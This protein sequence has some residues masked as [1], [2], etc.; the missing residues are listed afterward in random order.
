MIWKRTFEMR[1][2]GFLILWAFL[3]F[4]SGFAQD[5][6]ACL[7][8]HNDPELTME[9]KGREISLFIDP[10][11]FGKSAHAKASCIDC[12]SG[13]DPDE[14]PHKEDIQ[15][16][17]CA[18]CHRGEARAFH[19]GGH[20]QKLNCASCHQ[21]AHAPENK[22][23]L[24]L[25]CE[26]C[27]KEAK[28]SLAGS[29]HAGA[30][31]SPTCGNCHSP[32]QTGAVDSQKC[33]N[34]HGEKEFVH[35]HAPDKAEDYVLKYQDSI[36]GENIECSDCHGGHEIAPASSPESPV[37][38]SNI[39]NT[40]SQC[41]DEVAEKFLAS[42]HGKALQ[43]G[44][45]SAPTCTDCHG[46]HD[47]HQITDSRSKVSRQHEVEVC[48]KC[49]LDSPEVQA[50]MTHSAG[51]V[52]GY[53][54]S[55]HGRALKEGNLEAAVCSDC[56][57]GH[58]ELK[59]SAPNS[60]VNKFN[61]TS[62]CGTCHAS[63]S[64][65]FAASIHGQALLKGVNDS[66]TCTDCHGEHA[67]LEPSRSES[68]VA[69]QNVSRQVCAP[70]HNSVKMTGKFGLS[71]DRF[72]AYNDSYHGL[73]VQFGDIEAANCAS[74]HGV[75]NILP[76][77]DPRS[78]IHPANI[79]ATCG[80][81]HP[82]ANENFAKGQVHLTGREGESGLIYWIT[83]IYIS[84]I[85]ATIGS[86]AAHNLLDWIRKIRAKFRER[87]QPAFHYP[88]ERKTGLYVRM[89]VNERIQHA[90]LAISFLTLVFTGFMLK[91]PDAWWV[92]WIRKIGGEPLFALRGWLH[93][94]AAVVMVADSLY[95]IYYL[96]FTQRGRQ[97]FKDMMFRLQDVKDMLQML[98]YNLGLDKNRPRFDRFNYIEKSEYWALIWGTIVMTVT[99]FILWYA[100]QFMGWFSKS[101]VDVSS[102]IHYYEAWLAFLA[103]VVW[104]FYYVIFNP[105]VYPMNFAF[106]TGKL[107]EEEMEHEHPLE[108]EKIKEAEAAAA[109]E[110]EREA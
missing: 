105:D 7:D 106:L 29:V 39:L 72:S 58:D 53:E 80:S 89:T 12:H 65:E 83:A 95:H 42:E 75:H 17:N 99:G 36:H 93:R 67:I 45:A 52:A 104:H 40:C 4:S 15:P 51:F 109:G 10:A 62:T 37:N 28:N 34:C 66:P 91:F 32:H 69:P 110:Q 9:K 48:M 14:L 74:C 13:F 86:M 35:K 81:C 54:N 97:F 43:S 63:I 71:S 25:T 85:L 90:L 88:T 101:F 77:S 79:A 68:P 100:N 47:I 46:E 103:I 19:A 31:D 70:C 49:H 1:T 107:T 84:V 59:A 57:G 73:A 50:R 56:H 108:L 27:H 102:T 11:V 30:A 3:S 82:G 33:L 18:S 60:K 64:E 92:L 87:Y 5:N 76:S 24:A 61:I 41:H 8:C 38:H 23:A 16:V 78:N 94:A 21:N 20:A 44:F 6:E 2:A 26:S 98:K 96:A 55:I 22:K